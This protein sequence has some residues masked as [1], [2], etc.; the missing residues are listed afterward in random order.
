M[1]C[2]AID[3]V[4]TTDQVKFDEECGAECVKEAITPPLLWIDIWQFIDKMKLQT[5][6]DHTF[7]KDAS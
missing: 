1:D 4:T 5:I 3:F 6:W 2:S 7:G